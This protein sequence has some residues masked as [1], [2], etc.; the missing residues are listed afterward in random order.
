MVSN[1]LSSNLS[2]IPARKVPCSTV[3]FSSVG[4]QCAGIFRTVNATYAQNKF[5]TG[6]P[7]VA[8]NRR[9]LASS[10]NCRPLQIPTPMIMC[11]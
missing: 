10:D 8:G 9:Q 5:R 6:G 7:W 3:T 11:D 1:L 2:P 4:C